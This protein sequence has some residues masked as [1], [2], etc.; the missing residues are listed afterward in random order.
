MGITFGGRPCLEPVALY[1]SCLTQ[2]PPLPTA[3]WFGSANSF[4][5]PLGRTPGR[6]TLL[7]SRK[8]IDVLGNGNRN[9]TFDLKFL[10]DSNRLVTIKSLV[11]VRAVALS[12]G[13]SGSADTPYYLEIADQRAL[14]SMAKIDKAYNVRDGEGSTSAF[15]SATK[16]GGS[17]WT[18]ATMFA[19]LWSQH[20]LLGT[21]PSLPYTPD[22]TP[23][24]WIFWGANAWDAINDVL[25]RIGCAFKLDPLTGTKSIVRRGYDTDNANANAVSR[26]SKYR[27]WDTY[28]I[29]PEYGRLPE[30]ITVRFAKSPPLTTGASNYYTVDVADT[31]ATVALTGTRVILDDDLLALYDAT[32]TLTNSAALATRAAERAAAWFKAARLAGQRETL[33]FAGMHGVDV[34]C[35]VGAIYGEAAWLDRGKGYRT[36]L[37]AREGEAWLWGVERKIDSDTITVREVDTSPSVTASVLELPNSAM[38]NPSTG[39]ARLL[40]ASVSTGGTVTLAAGQVLGDGYKILD[41]G[42]VINDSGSATPTPTN[43]ALIVKTNGANTAAQFQNAILIQDVLGSTYATAIEDGGASTT[44][45]TMS[46]VNGGS[47]VTTGF[48]LGDEAFYGAE[49]I[50]IWRNDGVYRSDARYNVYNDTGLH[51]GVTSTLKPGAAS[52]GGII[53]NAGSGTFGDV[54]ASAADIT[55]SFAL[56]G[57][58][59]PAQLTA[60]TNDWNPTGW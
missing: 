13:K 5:C 23:E 12:P 34:I 24:G 55:G 1:E 8:D 52:V 18:W 15:L 44:I 49:G 56:S 30:K 36:A 31:T 43:Y 48:W 19:D 41:D 47:G 7:M 40:E 59:S 22:G 32:P 17:D 33:E 3:P 27:I 26:L 46:F 60:N 58:V 38:S 51:E 14:W 20:G 57:D 42:L 29:E 11:L 35:A 54:I 6:G 53:T 21:A 10:D 39:V 2:D 4:R 9:Q 37:A 45:A 28:E 16:N 50:T 25:D